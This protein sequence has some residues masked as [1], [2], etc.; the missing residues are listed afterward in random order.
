[1]PE[2]NF[3]DLLGSERETIVRVMRSLMAQSPQ[4]PYHEFILHT[5]EGLRRLSVWVDLIIRA[6][7]GRPE[8]FLED[9]KR[10]GYYR[11]VQGF[12][13]ENV[14][15]LYHSLQVSF[16]QI[17]QKWA[18]QKQLSSTEVAEALRNFCEIYT[19]GYACV[20]ASY[21]KTREEQINGKV[22]LLEQLQDFTKGLLASGEVDAVL[23]PSM[24]RIQSCFD[25]EEVYAAIC[26]ENCIESIYGY[27]RDRATE[28]VR[29]LLETCWN[30]NRALNLDE[31]GRELPFVDDSTVM[32]VVA[33]PIQA[34]GRRYGVIAVRNIRRGFRLSL[35]DSELLKQFVHILAMAL[36]NSFI[37]E[38]LERGRQELRLLAGK[39]ISIKEEERRKLASDIHDTLAQQLTGIDYKIQFGIELARCEPKKVPGQLRSLTKA[40]QN[41]IEHCRKLISELRPDLIDTVGLVAALKRL[42]QNYTAETGIKV[43][44]T[45]PEQLRLP[46][47]L[48]I[49]LFRVVQEALGNIQK[50]SKSATS[51]ITLDQSD[52]LIVLRVSDHGVGFDMKP[53]PPWIKNPDKLGLLY[54]RERVESVGGSL[55]I[56]TSAGHGCSL[57]VNIPCAQEAGYCGQSPCSDS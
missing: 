37:M 56:Q 49:C 29:S 41:T 38:Q 52:G 8:D 43:E 27:P 57:K 39:I 13:F 23:I 44:C 14:C 54:M 45:F 40:V 15:E 53:I 9:Q 20:A 30:Q 26:R 4:S 42:V 10:V 24:A 2:S 28:K 47:E 3:T 6:L 55:L 5:E 12:N 16:F 33:V 25:V 51:E 50:H 46:V 32:R 1:M 22:L 18:S 7:E 11:A 48:S 36:E 17:A 19:A 31:H 21:L 34:H 35:R